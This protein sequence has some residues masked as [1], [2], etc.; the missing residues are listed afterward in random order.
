MYVISDMKRQE[1]LS[2]L[3]SV[4]SAKCCETATNGTNIG[5]MTMQPPL[6]SCRVG[7]AYWSVAHAG[8]Q[9][10]SKDYCSQN[11]LA[12]SVE[13]PHLDSTMSEGEQVNVFSV[14]CFIAYFSQE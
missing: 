11:G 2:S 13:G 7:V 4:D 6:K 1:C 3:Q 12:D 14:L 5:S 8:T 10:K 9:A